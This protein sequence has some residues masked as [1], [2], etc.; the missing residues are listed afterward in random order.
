MIVTVV[1]SHPL[2]TPTCP[3]PRRPMVAIAPT[4]GPDRCRPHLANDIANL[5]PVPRRPRRRSTR[6]I[7]SAHHSRRGSPSCLAVAPRNCRL[8][9]RAT[10]FRWR[11]RTARRPLR[12]FQ[13]P[14]GAGEQHGYGGYDGAYGR[15][16]APRP[17]TTWRRTMPPRLQTGQREEIEKAINHLTG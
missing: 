12:R 17:E 16:D 15:Q 2:T 3:P 1:A 4:A 9:K 11:P 7:K 14:R 10:R 13:S 5:D 8:S 6:F